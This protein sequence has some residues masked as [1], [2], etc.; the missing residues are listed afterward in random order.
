MSG[1]KEMSKF[2]TMPAPK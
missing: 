1:E 2:E